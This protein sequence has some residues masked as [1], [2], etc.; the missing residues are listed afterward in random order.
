VLNFGRCNRR[1]ADDA[2]VPASLSGPY[3]VGCGK[4]PTARK[5]FADGDMKVD[6]IGSAGDYSRGIQKTTTARDKEARA[7]QQP[8]VFETAGL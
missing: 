1:P 3:L 2:D 6:A 5:A 8:P 7:S 4:E